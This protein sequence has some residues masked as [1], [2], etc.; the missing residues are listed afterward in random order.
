MTAVW[1]SGTERYVGKDSTVGEEAYSLEGSTV[2]AERQ[3]TT[4]E[5]TAVT[6]PGHL[7]PTN[8]T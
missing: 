3:Q 6:R 4:I 5:V 1:I 8:P 7:H 2:N